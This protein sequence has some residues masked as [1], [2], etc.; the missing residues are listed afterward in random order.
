MVNIY[1]ARQSIHYNTNNIQIQVP[2]SLGSGS[3]HDSAISGRISTGLASGSGVSNAPTI[4]GTGDSLPGNLTVTG[5]TTTI[6]GNHLISSPGTTISNYLI[7]GQ[8]EITANNCTVNN[9]RVRC[10]NGG[11]WGVQIGPG[12]TGTL[13]NGV[14]IG[15]G[16][17]GT[18]NTGV[19]SG[20]LFG[21]NSGSAFNNQ[22]NHVWVH[23]CIDGLRADGNCWFRQSKVTN[24]DT[25]GYQ[26]APGDGTH[27]DGSQSTGWGGIKFTHSYVDAGNNDALFFN[28]E[29]GNPAIGEVVIDNCVV[30]GYTGSQPGT[31][32]TWRS[33][34]GIRITAG[35]P[36]HVTNTQINGDFDG[37]AQGTFTTWSNNTRD[38]SPIGA[39]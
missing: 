39:P 20:I 36:C 19:G 11:T 8:L 12:V 34:Y 7:T 22:A 10:D 18:T 9:T 38:G 13:L 32:S 4:P 27:G 26:G 5:T 25:S 14:E 6:N 29:S 21:D 16:S 28:Q 31:P 33:S 3:A 24:M 1:I 35:G 23:H 15:G 30:N 17:N 2:T 37:Y